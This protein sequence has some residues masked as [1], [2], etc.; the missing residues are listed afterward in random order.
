MFIKVVLLNLHIGVS[1]LMA[2]GPGVSNSG[3]LINP[4]QWV[5]I[6]LTSDQ[7]TSL[8]RTRTVELTVN[9]RNTLGL[10]DTRYQQLKVADI[11][12]WNGCTCGPGLW[13]VWEF[14]DIFSIK[15]Q[16]LKRF[17]ERENHTRL[18]ELTPFNYVEW[19]SKQVIKGLEGKLYLNNKEISSKDAKAYLKEHKR[20]S[21]VSASPYVMNDE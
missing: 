9:Q 16:H 12:D 11:F 18:S 17:R 13:G 5:S 1:L 2:A 20:Y 15:K 10:E 8:S 6:H 14:R 7:M 3:E 4:E 19:M 21:V